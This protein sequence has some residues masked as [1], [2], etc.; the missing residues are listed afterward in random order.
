MPYILLTLLI[1]GALVLGVVGIVKWQESRN[2]GNAQALRQ[3]KGTI[4]E[5]NY[6]LA[7][8]RAQVAIASESLNQ[9]RG[10]WAHNPAGNANDALDQM[11]AIEQ[12]AIAAELE[13]G[14]K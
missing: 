10:N 5:K 9:I 2:S 1:L 8:L 13:R 11:N 3:A 14:I 4:L 12:A 6:E 7:S